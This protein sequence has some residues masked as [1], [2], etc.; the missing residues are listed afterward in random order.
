MSYAYWVCPTDITY[1][2]LVA[3]GGAAVVFVS[4]SRISRGLET[5]VLRVCVFV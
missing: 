1:Q 5:D 4:T 3:A 2:P